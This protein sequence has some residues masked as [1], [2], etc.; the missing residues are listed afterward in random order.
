MGVFIAVALILI[1]MSTLFFYMLK[2]AIRRLGRFSK[3]N[4][5]HEANVYDELLENKELELKALLKQI[6]TEQAKVAEEAQWAAQS[7]GET[8]AGTSNFF[9]LLKGRYLDK[10]FTAG[11]QALRN[12]FTVDKGACV[13]S[14]V[15][16]TDAAKASGN[17]AQDILEAISIELRYQLS[18]LDRDEAFAIIKG[19]FKGKPAKLVDSY[20]EEEPTGDIIAFFDWLNVRSFTDSPDVVVRTG[21]PSDLASVYGGN[22][23]TQFDPSVCEGVYVIAGGRMHDFSIRS[24]EISG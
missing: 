19:S 16:L 18:L 14:V 15:A 13:K 8:K 3:L 11:Y 4:M 17:A 2:G 24:R 20:L 21:N 7:P 12:Q 22:V 10:D 5:I 1:L 23:V 9:T 6:E